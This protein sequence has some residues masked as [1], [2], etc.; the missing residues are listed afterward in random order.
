[1]KWLIESQSMIEH[2]ASRRFRSL[3]SQLAKAVDVSAWGSTRLLHHTKSTNSIL[4][5]T[6]TI[7]QTSY[8]LSEVSGNCNLVFLDQS[9][10]KIVAS[11]S[12][13]NHCSLQEGGSLKG[14]YA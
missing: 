9:F 3:R 14:M 2:L 4:S 11:V 13:V 1:M 6:R 7:W 12:L 5:Y 8:C 10:F